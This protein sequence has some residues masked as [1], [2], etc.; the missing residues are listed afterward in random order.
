MEIHEFLDATREVILDRGWTTGPAGWMTRGPVCVEGGM[1]QALRIHGP[2]NEDCVHLTLLDAM[3]N[4]PGYA[5]M[6]NYLG[7][8][9]EQLW[10]WNDEATE[11]QVLD[12]LEQ[13]ANLH[14]MG[15]IGDP[16]REIEYEPLEAPAV[17]PV[18][19]PDTPAPLREPVPA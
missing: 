9:V 18:T 16:L 7:L 11:E 14:R 8:G 13:C 1:R 5:A 12:A 2:D 4:H 19:V 10:G 6:Q 15:N 3:Q 17:E